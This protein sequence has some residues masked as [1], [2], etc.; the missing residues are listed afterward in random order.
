MDKL[1]IELFIK[2]ITYLPFDDVTSLCQTNT[3]FH[4]YCTNPKYE[5]SWRLL[6]KNT[7]SH[8]DDYETNLSELLE[9]YNGYNYQ[10]YTNFV[11]LLDPVTQGMIYYKQRDMKSFSKLTKNQKFIALFLL[12]EKKEL[13]YYLNL[14]QEGRHYELLTRYGMYLQLLDGKLLRP[15][16]LTEILKTMINE[17]SLIG[18]KYLLKVGARIGED[19]L[20]QIVEND[21]LRILKYLVENDVKFNRPYI[22]LVAISHGKRNMVKYLN[23]K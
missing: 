19:V 7:F 15:S 22:M 18:V 16:E 3:K 20:Y 9:K 23:Q 8:L 13:Y 1:P 21:R 12:G 2:Q 4:E 10:V 5:N 6:I 17:D 11:K 14:A